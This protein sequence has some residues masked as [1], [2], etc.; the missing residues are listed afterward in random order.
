MVGVKLMYISHER[1]PVPV[2]RVKLMYISHG[3]F[4]PFLASFGVHLKGRV[5]IADDMGLGK[6]LQAI[7]LA[8]VYRSKWPVL[9]VTPSSVRFDWAQVCKHGGNFIFSMRYSN[10]LSPWHIYIYSTTSL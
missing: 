7:C 6:T 4:P 9:V 1:E 8:C 10:S 5:L 3:C 2:V